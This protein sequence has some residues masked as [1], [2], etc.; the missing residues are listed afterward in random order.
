[1]IMFNFSG[2]YMY[3]GLLIF[4][5]AFCRKDVFMCFALVLQQTEI[6]S[7]NVIKYGSGN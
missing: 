7:L 5:S 1:M 3:H 4:K 2:Y 6:I